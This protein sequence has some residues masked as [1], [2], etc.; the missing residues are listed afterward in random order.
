MRPSIVVLFIARVIERTVCR[1]DPARGAR[2]PVQLTRRPEPTA[3]WFPDP[4]DLRD[5]TIEFPV[6][7]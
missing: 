7:T 5:P 3:L 1:V 4:P 2:R 6:G